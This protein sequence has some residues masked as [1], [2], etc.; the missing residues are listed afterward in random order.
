MERKPPR[1]RPTTKKE[2]SIYI[3]IHIYIYI[4]IYIHTHYT[5]KYT[6]TYIYIY[7]PAGWNKG[8]HAPALCTA[9]KGTF[10]SISIHA[11]THT[12]IYIRK[13]TRTYMCMTQR[14]RIRSATPPPCSRQ[15]RMWN[16]YP[17]RHLPTPGNH[18]TM[19]R[20]TRVHIYIHIYT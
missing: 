20:R 7:D 6:H 18:L 17:E 15:E 5:H 3:N 1:P 9:E 16:T 14:D 12:Y 2:T 11:H 10:I 19:N 8:R 13:H 4:Y